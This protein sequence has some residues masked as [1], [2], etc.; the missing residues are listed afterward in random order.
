MKTAQTVLGPVPVTELAPILI[1][2]HVICTSPV[3]YRTFGEKWFSGETLRNETV[4][5]L[6]LAKKTFG[7][8]TIVDATPLNLGRDPGLL[9]EISRISGVNIIAS[10]GMYFYEDFT[11]S[12][13]PPEILA[14]LFIDE[15]RNG[16]PAGIRPGFLKCAADA[17]GITPYVKRIHELTAFIQAATGLPVFAHTSPSANTGPEQLEIL[18]QNGADPAK[19]VMGHCGD[20][21][22]PDYAE[23]LLKRGCYVSIDRIY[24]NCPQWSAGKVS[25]LLE[26][27][28]RGWTERLLTAH[29]LI[30]FSDSENT[31]R[32]ALPDS[33]K[34]SPHCDPKGLCVIH[35][36]ILPELRKHGVSERELRIIME[37]NPLKLF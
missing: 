24:R 5:K 17:A 10:T 18:I 11:V 27:I 1:H 8:R 14:E 16:D 15:C 12:T 13:I 35:D 6:T 33:L 4:R 23:T 2:E 7:L 25:V 21:G 31:R 37:E 29:D 32:D 30:L 19:I 22:K 36:T 34:N 28:R 9:A 26:L 3:I 20:S